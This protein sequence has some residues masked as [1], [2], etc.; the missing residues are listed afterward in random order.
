L[1]WLKLPYWP[2][3]LG[4]NELLKKAPGLWLL[5]MKNTS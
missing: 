5:A 3:C 4:E 2:Q 1:K